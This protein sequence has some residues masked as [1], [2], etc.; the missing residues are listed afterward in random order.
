M[1]HLSFLIAVVTNFSNT[2]CCVHI[3]SGPTVGILPPTSLV[4]LTLL[5]QGLLITKA[6]QSHSVQHITRGRTP[7]DGQSAQHRN[8]YLTTHNLHNRQTSMPPA[9]CAP[10][11]PTNG[12]PQPTPWTTLP[13]GSATVSNLRN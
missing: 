13:L 9:K 8:L 1:N 4:R 12:Q 3:I 7:L 11:N 10:A 6:S 5:V 2:L